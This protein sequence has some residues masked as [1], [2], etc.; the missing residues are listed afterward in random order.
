MEKK[1]KN[2]TSI[3]LNEEIKPWIYQKMQ[4][5]NRSLG[6]LVNTILKQEKKRE[7]ITKG[8]RG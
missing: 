5:E 3:R 4:D 6:N 2:S 7:E 1:Y 8:E